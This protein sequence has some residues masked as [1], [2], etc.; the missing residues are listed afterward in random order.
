MEARD[1]AIEPAVR[2]D[3]ERLRRRGLR[4]AWFIVVW[5]VIEGAIAATAGLAAGSSR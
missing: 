2:R 3:D 5:D 1:V 4:L